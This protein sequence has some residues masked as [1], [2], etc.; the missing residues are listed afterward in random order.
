MRQLREEERRAKAG[1]WA[2]AQAEQRRLEEAKDE[3]DRLTQAGKNRVRKLREEL[4]SFVGPNIDRKLYRTEHGH[5]LIAHRW[6]GSA[7]GGE[8]STDVELLTES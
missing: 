5:V 8:Y 3:A 7:E 4:E 2:Q 1:E 6:K